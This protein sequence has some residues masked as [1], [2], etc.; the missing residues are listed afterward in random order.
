MLCGQNSFSSSYSSLWS[1]RRCLFSVIFSLFILCMFSILVGYGEAQAAYSI[2]GTVTNNTS[3]PGRAYLSLS[4]QG[5]GTTNLGVSVLVAANSSAPFNIRG[6]TINGSYVI[7]GFLDTTGTGY[8]F[9]NS[10]TGSSAAIP[11]NS[12][13]VSGV[14]LTLSAQGP[15]A[16]SGAIAAPKIATNGTGVAVMLDQSYH[17]N[18]PANLY[19]G[20]GK[21]LLGHV[22]TA[23]QCH[24][25][26]CYRL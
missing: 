6:V 14:S 21:C 15:V 11:L 23:R 24:S 13:N 20:I 16:L 2:S 10:A 26:Q 7:N 18:R 8:Q 19:T 5:G 9:A 4:M 12:G 25:C 22:V 17:E 1:N 3:S